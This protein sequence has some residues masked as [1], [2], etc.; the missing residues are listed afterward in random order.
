[1]P[2]TIASQ[3]SSRLGQF[4]ALRTKCVGFGEPRHELSPHEPQTAGNATVGD[5]N[6]WLET[7][8]AT[9]V[10]EALA[11]VVASGMTTVVLTLEF[12]AAATSGGATAQESPQEFQV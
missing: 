7:V 11:I 12:K 8:F 10:N 1:M 4:A 3:T 6:V 9:V 2:D 5:A